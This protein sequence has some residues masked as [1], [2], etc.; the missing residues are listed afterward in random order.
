[1][2]HQVEYDVDVQAA[3]GKRAEPMD[4]DKSRIRHD[5]SAATSRVEA[6]GVSG[7]QHHPT[8]SGCLDQSIGFV[9]R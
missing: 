6:L 9:Q 3:F 8:A 4:L 7:S 2:N 5:G 1:M